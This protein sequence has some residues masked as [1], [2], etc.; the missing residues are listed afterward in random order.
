M[1]EGSPIRDAGN[2]LGYLEFGG[3]VLVGTP[4]MDFLW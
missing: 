2:G 4:L 3:V 1:E